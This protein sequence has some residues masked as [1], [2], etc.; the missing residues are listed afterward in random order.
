MSKRLS[1]HFTF[2]ISSNNGFLCLLFGT[3]ISI[4]LLHQDVQ[5]ALPLADEDLPKAEKC[6]QRIEGNWTWIDKSGNRMSQTDLQVILNEHAKWTGTSQKEGRQADLSGARLKFL[7]PPNVTLA[8]VNF[9]NSDLTYSDFRR[10]N[11]GETVLRGANLTCAR[12]EGAYLGGAD[13]TDTDLSSNTLLDARFDHAILTRTI[14]RGKVLRGLIFIEAKM[15]EAD[16]TGS[17]LTNAELNGADLSNAKLTNSLLINVNLNAA[18]LEGADLSGATYEVS[19]HPTPKAIAFAKN[20]EQMTH[21]GDSA[22]L[23]QLRA[24]FKETGFRDQER[25]ITYA[26]KSRQGEFL[27]KACERDGGICFEY[28]VNRILFDLTS[29]YGMN[30]GRVLIIVLIIFSGSTLLYWGLIHRSSDSGLSIIVPADRDRQNQPIWLL[31]NLS[32]T[33]EQI[34]EGGFITKKGYSIRPKDIQHPRN[35]GY[36]KELVRREWVLLRVSCLF[37]LM[38]TFNLKFRDV[39]FGRWLRQLMTKEYDIK[40]KGWVRTVS[41]IQALLSLYFIALL[42]ITYFGRPFE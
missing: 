21:T 37:S 16:L 13:L 10:S 14:L 1:R 12:L 24:L 11:L 15:N 17:D 39:D 31:A 41:G 7:G 38:S 30:P 6:D 26:L 33:G 9:T 32:S 25:K 35:L 23:A 22:S 29:Q 42:L 27:W 19:T 36:W 5:G 18:N 3:A 28:W 20:I 4:L 2:R 34:Q 40:A 8:K